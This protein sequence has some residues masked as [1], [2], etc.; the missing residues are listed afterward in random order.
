MQHQ[1]LLQAREQQVHRSA[2]Y[3][4]PPPWLLRDLK[5]RETAKA[6]CAAKIDAARAELAAAWPDTVNRYL[7]A[8]AEVHGVDERPPAAEPVKRGPR[9]TVGCDPS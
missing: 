8:L 2:S 9:Q 1:A 5:A 3:I 4:A 7:D 6:A